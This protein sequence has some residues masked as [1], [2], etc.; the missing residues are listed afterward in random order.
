MI[1]Q[2]PRSAEPTEVYSRETRASRRSVRCSGRMPPALVRATIT[3]S[4]GSQ[5]TFCDHGRRR[6]GIGP[7][8]G[9]TRADRPVRHRPRHHRPHAP[10]TQGSND[11][12]GRQG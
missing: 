5:D 6:R 7:D 3:R 12:T 2:A 10:G 8:I 11:S 4:A 1:Q 9:P